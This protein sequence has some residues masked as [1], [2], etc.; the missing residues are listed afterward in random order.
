MVALYERY[1]I[2]SPN[3]IV[4]FAHRSRTSKSVQIAGQSL[5]RGGSI[6]DFGAGTGLMLRSLG[7]ARPDAEL[8]AIE[9]YQQHSGDA[10]IRY[11]ASFD[12]LEGRKLDVITAF[13]VCEHLTDEQLEDFFQA[14]LGSLKSDGRIIISVPIVVGPLL[15]LKEINHMV[16]YRRR[17]EYTFGEFVMNLAGMEIRRPKV[18]LGTHKGFDFRWMRRQIEKRFA[19]EKEFYSPLALP[20]W[21]NS[22]AFFI[23]SHRI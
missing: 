21:L 22:Q 23:C 6:L 3:P 4:R 1:T 11:V 14:S 13:E 16:L 18:R 8:I 17:P 7:D 15:P 20:W 5:P 9:P 12:Q 19:I 2:H 10:R